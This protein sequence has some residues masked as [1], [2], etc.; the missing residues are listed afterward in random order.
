[1]AGRSPLW[2]LT[3]HMAT[4]TRSTAT[5]E[6]GSI[7]VASGGARGEAAP[8]GTVHLVDGWQPLCGGERVRFVFPGR[9]LDT[10]ADCPACAAKVAQPARRAARSSRD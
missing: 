9:T 6:L 3:V 2:A 7:S 1:M 4:R 5:L 10:D 8:S